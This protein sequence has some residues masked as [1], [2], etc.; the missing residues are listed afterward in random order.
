MD[1]INKTIFPGTSG[2]P[3][4]N[5]IAAVG[6]ALIELLDE[7]VYPDKVPFNRYIESV[8]NNAKSLEDGLLEAGVEIVSKTQNHIVLA[9]LPNDVDSLQ[10]QKHLEKLGI[11]TNR[12]SIPYDKK[13]AW[14]PGGL[15]MG[16]AALTSRGLNVENANTLGQLIG[17]VITSKKS[18]K[19][20][21]FSKNLASELAWWYEEL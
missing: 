3:H 6:Q 10:L 14:V 1:S 4:L 7:D 8:V 20:A 13:S 2:G 17:S 11:I 21:D 5:Q 16:T 15:R 18:T 12:N 9:K 19:L